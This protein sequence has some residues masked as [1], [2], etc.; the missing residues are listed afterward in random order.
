MSLQ[1]KCILGSQFRLCSHSWQS[2][3]F[4]LVQWF[5]LLLSLQRT[6]SQCLL[7]SSITIERR[8]PQICCLNGRDYDRE[9][10]YHICDCTS[11][12]YEWWVAVLIKNVYGECFDPQP[13]ER[14]RE[15][16]NNGN[17]L[18]MNKNCNRLGRFWHPQWIAWV[19]CTILELYVHSFLDRISMLH[20]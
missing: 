1:S 13:H 18:A 15:I 2:I 20:D 7:G 8:K 11:E 16:M 19:S 10:D 14:E 3:T 6:E 12:D 9:F 5:V 17:T 4:L